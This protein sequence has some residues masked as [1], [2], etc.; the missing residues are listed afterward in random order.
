MTAFGEKLL[1]VNSLLAELCESCSWINS[2]LVSCRSKELSV[3]RGML[4][5]IEDSSGFRN[6]RRERKVLFSC[7]VIHNGKHEKMALRMK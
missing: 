6:D 1:L 2:L 7:F 4:F 3:Q 5:T